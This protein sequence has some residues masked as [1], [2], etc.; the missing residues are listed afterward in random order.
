M[1]VLLYHKINATNLCCHP[2]HS[3]IEYVLIHLILQQ[4]QNVNINAL[5]NV[6]YTMFP[7]NMDEVMPCSSGTWR[8]IDW[9]TL[10]IFCTSLDAHWT[11]QDRD[12]TKHVLQQ[13]LASLQSSLSPKTSPLVPSSTSLWWVCKFEVDSCSQSLESRV[14]KPRAIPT[15]PLTEFLR[16][17]F[18]C[19]IQNHYIHALRKYNGLL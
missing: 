6:V 18:T 14:P 19:Q 7:G 4:N 8:C 16:Q 15:F 1:F 3:S 11:N 12:I 13:T 9:A 2:W 10:F 5:C 17:V